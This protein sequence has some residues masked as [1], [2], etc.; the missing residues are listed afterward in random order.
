MQNLP[1]RRVSVRTIAAPAGTD[2]VVDEIGLPDRDARV[3]AGKHDVVERFAVAGVTGRRRAD[4]PI[5]ADLVKGR[6]R[7]GVAFGHK[8]LRSDLENEMRGEF[9][10]A[11][12][13]AATVIVVERR[14]PGC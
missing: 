5:V 7:P 13:I 2:Q 3:L 4:A 11:A 12:E 1:P 14:R 8:L 10:F 6:L 9:P